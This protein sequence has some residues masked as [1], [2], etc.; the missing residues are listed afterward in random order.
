MRNRQALRCGRGCASILTNLLGFGTPVPRRTTRRAAASRR[1][2][3][4]TLD[5]GQCRRQAERT[6]DLPRQGVGRG[7][8][9]QRVARRGGQGRGFYR[10][11]QTD[12]GTLFVREQDLRNKPTAESAT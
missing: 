5:R 1:R 4:Q 6:L 8:A 2:F 7:T 11:G 12:S 9:G 3:Q 10:L